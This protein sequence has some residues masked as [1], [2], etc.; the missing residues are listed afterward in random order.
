MFPFLRFLAPAAVLI[1]TVNASA[2]LIYSPLPQ[3][4]VVVER[5]AEHDIAVSNAIDRAWEIIDILDASGVANVPFYVEVEYDSFN[6]EHVAIVTIDLA[7]GPNLENSDWLIDTVKEIVDDGNDVLVS[8]EQRLAEIE[9]EIE[10]Q[11][12]AERLEA[13]FPEYMGEY[14]DP[15]YTPPLD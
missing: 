14:Y 7:Y 12:E 2:D 5:H 9:A 11:M 3:S 13:K 15:T 4:V 8:Q 10:A 6:D 1:F